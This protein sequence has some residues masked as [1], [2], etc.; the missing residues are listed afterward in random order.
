MI[1]TMKINR[2][3]NLRKIKHQIIKNQPYYNK[4]KMLLKKIQKREIL[5]NKFHCFPKSQKII[6]RLIFNKNIYKN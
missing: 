6:K 5:L 1:T 3:K 2:F 4:L